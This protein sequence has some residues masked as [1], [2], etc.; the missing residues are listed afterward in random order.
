MNI[1]LSHQVDIDM[2]V[3]ECQCHSIPAGCV[4]QHITTLLCLCICTSNQ[5]L[6]TNHLSHSF[7]LEPNF[8]SMSQ[9]CWPSAGCWWTR[10]PSVSHRVF[11]GGGD[12]HKDE[13]LP[14]LPLT[15]PGSLRQP[16][17]EGAPPEG[18]GARGGQDQREDRLSGLTVAAAL[19]V[20]S[21]DLR[22]SWILTSCPLTG[23]DCGVSGV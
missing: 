10:P 11:S 6:A 14:L 18:E 7:V 4:N 23:A 20:H 13:L 21:C 5:S 17:G 16:L 1:R 3:N 2:T 19:T 15:L 22:M 9:S 12:V 8:T